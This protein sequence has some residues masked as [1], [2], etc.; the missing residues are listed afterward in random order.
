MNG[1]VF[2]LSLFLACLSAAPILIIDDRLELEE[3]ADDLN[4][5]INNWTR[6]NNVMMP[7]KQWTKIRLGLQA[8]AFCILYEKIPEDWDF[9]FALMENAASSSFRS[10]FDYPLEYQK[11]SFLRSLYCALKSTRR[12]EEITTILS[13]KIFP[14]HEVELLSQVIPI[15]ESCTEADRLDFESLS[16]ESSDELGEEHVK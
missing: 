16:I 5:Q 3:L 15:I 9:M 2:L 8:D 11:E 13:S 4:A 10:L 1:F 14:G 6:E 7:R 12:K